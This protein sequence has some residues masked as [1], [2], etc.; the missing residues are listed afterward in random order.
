MESQGNLAYE[1][2]LVLLG[3]GIGLGLA[4]TRI[5]EAVRKRLDTSKWTE[6]VDDDQVQ[7]CLYST[8]NLR[9]LG[10]I[11]KR[12]IYISEALSFFGNN[13]LIL[14]KVRDAAYQSC[15]DTP[16]VPR[17]LSQDDR[18]HIMNICL[19]R[20]SALFGPFHVFFNEAR[21]SKS[22]YRSAWYLYTLT[23]Q[24]NAQ[25]GRFFVTPYKPVLSSADEGVKRLRVDLVNEQ[26]MRE[27]A[28]GVIAPPDWGFF[29]NR[30]K[31]RWELLTKMSELF[32]NQLVIIENC[33][34][35]SSSMDGDE[36]P[37]TPSSWHP[38]HRHTSNPGEMARH[39]RRI[40]CKIAKNHLNDSDNCIMRVHLPFPGETDEPATTKDVVLFE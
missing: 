10:R 38:V 11:E 36:S 33:D 39:A 25:R 27:I 28:S 32:E 1:S 37:S 4:V 34:G 17:F 13:S 9:T 29:N 5:Y 23:S 26:E 18:W 16:F 2:K 8:E 30:H 3:L 22:R 31:Q 40:A 35:D 20:I 14:D 6:H 19:N 12:T 24:K 21:R 7:I 15:E